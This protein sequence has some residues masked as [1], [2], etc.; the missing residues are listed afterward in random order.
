MKH[1]TLSDYQTMAIKVYFFCYLTIGNIKYR[2]GEFKK[3]LDYHI[4][5]QGASYRTIG[6][7]TQKKL[8]VAHL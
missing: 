3:L 2:I 1:I 8:S 4:S 5:D 7:Q 6:Y